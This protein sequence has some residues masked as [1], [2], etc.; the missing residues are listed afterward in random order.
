[1][2]SRGRP[3]EPAL[4]TPIAH[5]VAARIEG[6][7]EREFVHDP[8]KM[9]RGLE[10]LYKAIGTDGIFTA[11]A[12]AMEAEA[13]GADLDWTMY[14]PRVVSP[15]LQNLSEALPLPAKL[16]AAARI[17]AALETTRRLAATWAEGPLLAA[18][19]TGPWTLAGQLVGADR[20][21][22]LGTNDRERDI[23]GQVCAEL[24]RLYCEAGAHMIVVHEQTRP[25][26]DGGEDGVGH[27][28]R[29]AL[30]PLINIVSF[31]K[32]LVVE[33][34]ADDGN[35]GARVGG[36]GF[37]AHALPGDPSQWRIPPTPGSLLITASEVP[38]DADFPGLTGKCRE[39]MIQLA[40]ADP[41]SV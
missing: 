6:W 15:P 5:A 20:L 23:C 30:V 19:V 32:K 36:K 40:P 7:D 14:P 18:V 31:H 28:W 10:A 37:A 11:A 9:S 17:E 41:R 24:A 3:I 27:T 13:A 39:I 4:F 25:P 34:A 29:E 12:A 21:K 16:N 8:A 1:M 2:L 33:I 35:G 38:S 26:G 22:E